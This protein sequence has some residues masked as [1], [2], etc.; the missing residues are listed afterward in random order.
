MVSRKNC[1][2]PRSQSSR[3]AVL[4]RDPSSYSDSPLPPD[5]SVHVPR[6]TFYPAGSFG[7]ALMFVEPPATPACVFCA[8]ETL[9]PP[10]VGGLASA[11]QTNRPGQCTRRLVE[12]DA[13]L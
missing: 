11:L 1:A 3:R 9:R 7:N 10:A 8:R 5:A 13:K 12:R 6:R 2:V 4:S